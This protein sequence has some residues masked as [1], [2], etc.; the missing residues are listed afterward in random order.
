MVKM[1]E[2]TPATSALFA[3]LI[4]QH[5][6]PNQVAVLNGDAA[7]A[8]EFAR[9]PFSH[10][11]FTGSIKTGQ[12]VMRSAAANLT[13]VTLELGGKSPAI[14][15]PESPMAHAAERVMIGKCLSAG[16]SCIAPDYVLLPGGRE[17]E[18]VDAARRTMAACYPNIAETPDYSHITSGITGV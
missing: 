12:S 14:I 6:R 1:S 7:V 11:L 10:L 4:A 2:Y 17:E 16:Q 18:F 15:G 3:T 8:Q 9:L 13:P 5:F